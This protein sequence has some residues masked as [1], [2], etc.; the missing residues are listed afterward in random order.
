M[1]DGRTPLHFAASMGDVQVAEL[2]LAKGADIEAK[3]KVGATPFGD[4]SSG[5]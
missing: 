3:D 5:Y 2:L 1:Q 4:G